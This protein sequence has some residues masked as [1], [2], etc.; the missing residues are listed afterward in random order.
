MSLFGECSDCGRSGQ[1]RHKPDVP[2]SEQS[3]PSICEECRRD[4]ERLLEEYSRSES[5]R[6]EYAQLEEGSQ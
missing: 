6:W 1:L 4:R 3:R 2:L 5:I